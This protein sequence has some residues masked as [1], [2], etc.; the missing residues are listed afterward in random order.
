MRLSDLLGSPAPLGS[1]TRPGIYTRAASFVGLAVLAGPI[2]GCAAPAA[3]TSHPGWCYI[4]TT[5][6]PLKRGGLCCNHGFPGR[7]GGIS[8]GLLAIWIVWFMP[9]TKR[10]I[11]LKVSE[12]ILTQL[13]LA[14]TMILICVWY[15]GEVLVHLANHT[16]YHIN[17]LLAML[18][19]SFLF[20]LCSRH[21]CNFVFSVIY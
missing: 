6:I 5:A 7:G 12:A 13:P 4:P 8:P 2:P 16:L 14:T 21:Y 11:G 18:A 3:P 17:L 9:I 1:R 10:F 19:K 20:F 15:W